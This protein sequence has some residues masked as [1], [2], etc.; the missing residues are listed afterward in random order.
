MGYFFGQWTLFLFDFIAISLKFTKLQFRFDPHAFSIKVWKKNVKFYFQRPATNEYMRDLSK[1]VL[2]H[3]KVVDI[4]SACEILCSY[5]MNDDTIFFGWSN[6]IS[7]VSLTDVAWSVFLK[8]E[9]RKW[10]IWITWGT[11]S[12]P[13]YFE[14]MTRNKDWKSYDKY[15]YCILWVAGSQ[16]L[17]NEN[18]YRM[19]YKS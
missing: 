4:E 18:D 1:I 17:P 6:M 10:W 3:E 9:K 14:L 16:P 5:F 12:T 15:T 13:T 7:H 19:L 11:C 2:Y 8:N